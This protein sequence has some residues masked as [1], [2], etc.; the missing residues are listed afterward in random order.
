MLKSY[1]NPFE[2]ALRILQDIILILRI[3]LY[4]NF[5]TKKFYGEF[6]EFMNQFY[7]LISPNQNEL[8]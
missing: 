1:E 8:T 6:Y 3:Y 7:V 2:R 4:I 5:S